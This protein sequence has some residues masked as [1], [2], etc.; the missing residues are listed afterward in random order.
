MIGYLLLALL[1]IGAVG[2]L[3][4]ELDDDD[5]GGTNSPQTPGEDTGDDTQ[6]TD[7]DDLL[8][9]AMDDDTLEGG[10]GDDRLIGMGGDDE[11]SGDA[12]NDHVSGDDGDDILAGGEGDDGIYG[13]SG[14]DIALGGAGDDDIWGG[15]NADLLV[16]GEGADTMSGSTGDDLL[17]GT[18]TALQDGSVEDFKAGLAEGETAPEALLTSLALSGTGADAD[19]GD[20][21]NGGLGDDVMLV[22]SE[23]TASS[24]DGN[25]FFL[26]GDWIQAGR[27]AEIADYD[28]DSD[29]IAFGFNTDEAP[30]LT[31]S[32]DDEGNAVISADGEVLATV[33]GAAGTLSAEDIAVLSYED[34][35]TDGVA[36]TGTDEADDIRGSLN[37]D[38]VTGQGGDDSIT[39]LAGDDIARGNAGDDAIAMGDGDDRAFGNDGADTMTGGAG[40]DF[41]RGGDDGDSLTDTE[42]SDTLQGDAGDDEIIGSSF[43]SAEGPDGDSTGDELYGG[44]GDDQITFGDDDTVSGG[45]GAD[46]LTTSAA[47]SG[48]LITDFEIGSD[49]LVVNTAAGATPELAITYSDGATATE[50]DATVTLDGMPFMTVQ[51]VGTG[52]TASDITLQE[53]APATA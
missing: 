24:G 30:E 36:V 2:G 18:Q 19:A 50:G 49:M 27:A 45:L 47:T 6:G 20:E 9:G 42:G 11:V 43:A 7:G 3:I 15:S 40:D 17:I 32:D 29:Q 37:D 48:S 22:G 46:T 16:G 25:D 31:V 41:L 33:T 1:G 39:L 52:F 34:D 28:P 8:Q 23:D 26:M 4:Y 53:A 51:G 21:M 44:Q 38:V 35:I 13:G 10:A 5:D 14:S 12:G